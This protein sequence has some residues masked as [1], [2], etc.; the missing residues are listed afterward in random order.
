MFVISKEIFS[1]T[2]PDTILKRK[3]LRRESRNVLSCSSPE[4]T[5]SL[6]DL[7]LN[8]AVHMKSNQRPTTLHLTGTSKEDLGEKVFEQ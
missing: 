7:Q 6:V 2:N 4:G 1:Y 3:G 5:K 8:I